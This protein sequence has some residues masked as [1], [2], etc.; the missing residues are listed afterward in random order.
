MAPL[1]GHPVRAGKN[2]AIHTY[3]GAAACAQYGREYNIVVLAC[4]IRCLRKRQT[5]GIVGERYR[6]L[7]QRTQ[8]VLHGLSV[9]PGGVTVLHPARQAGNTARYGDAYGYAANT[10][11]HFC[12]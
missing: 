1:T 7:Q 6:P 2:L 11:L 8:V 10:S 12:L 3:T 4:A 9:K 5:I